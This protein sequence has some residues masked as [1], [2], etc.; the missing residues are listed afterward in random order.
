M[1]AETIDLDSTAP[2]VGLHGLRFQR[3]TS[4]TRT[5]LDSSDIKTLRKKTEDDPGRPAYILTEPWAGYRLRDPND[6]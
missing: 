5:V 2:I 3:H 1:P 6:P 4:L